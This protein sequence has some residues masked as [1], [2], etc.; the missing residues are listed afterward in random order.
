MGSTEPI[1]HSTL[2]V[3]LRDHLAAS[4]AA[5]RLLQRMCAVRGATPLGDEITEITSEVRAEQELLRSLIQHIGG[6]DRGFTLA[7]AWVGEKLSRFK[8]G[9]GKPWDSGLQLFET[10]EAISLAFYGRQS[11]WHTLAELNLQGALGIDTDFRALADRASRHLQAV[12]RARL[13]ASRRALFES[14]ERLR[15]SV[16]RPIM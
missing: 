13:V 4:V 14:G 15:D 2:R 8:L 5:I 3:Y 10:L 7:L 11:L 16:E 9:P 6:A 1:D 12:E